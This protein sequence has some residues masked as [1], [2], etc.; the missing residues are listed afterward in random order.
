MDLTVK[1]VAII[2]IYYTTGMRHGKRS[3]SIFPPHPTH[4]STS[5]L[6]LGFVIAAIYCIMYLLASVFPAPLS[7]AKQ[8]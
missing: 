7:P 3:S 2:N 6:W 5:A 1:L 4:L 8:E